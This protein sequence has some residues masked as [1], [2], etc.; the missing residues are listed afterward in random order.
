MLAA[1]MLTDI[2]SNGKEKRQNIF[3]RFKSIG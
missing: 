1:G 3:G 2:K